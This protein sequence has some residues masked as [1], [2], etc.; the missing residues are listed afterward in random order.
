MRGVEDGALLDSEGKMASFRSAI[1]VFT[2][3]R[4][5]P[6][7]SSGGDGDGGSSGGEGGAGASG[8][9][10]AGAHGASAVDTAAAAAPSMEAAG[11]SAM[12]ASPTSS[13]AAASAE[14]SAAAAEAPAAAERRSAAVRGPPPLSG[15]V[16]DLLASVDA[17]ANF[18]ALSPPDTAR[19]VEVRLAS[20]ARQLCSG[21][22][23]VGGGGGSCDGGGLL[24]GLRWEPGAVEALAAAGH[25]S[26]HGLRP[27]SGVLRQRV[28]GPLADTMLQAAVDSANAAGVDAL[29][30]GGSGGRRVAVL[31]AARDGGVFVVLEAA[32]PG[33]NPGST[34]AAVAGG[35]WAPKCDRAPIGASCWLDGNLDSQSTVWQAVFPNTSPKPPSSASAALLNFA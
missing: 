2:L 33:G 28:L 17:V 29:A 12:M 7:G 6:G 19:I 21:N 3:S 20:L 27:L 31:R 13:P 26:V 1:V 14:A 9:G 23:D 15:A 35:C 25:S 24:A 4:P 5:L 22:G 18:R 16:R 30:G 11:A 8:S 32:G 34:W 10:A